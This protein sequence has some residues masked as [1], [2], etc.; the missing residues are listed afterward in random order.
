MSANDLRCGC[1][2]V[3]ASEQPDP[4]GTMMGSGLPVL[5]VDASQCRLEALRAFVQK[6]YDETNCICRMNRLMDI[7]FG[8]RSGIECTKCQAAELLGLSPEKGGEKS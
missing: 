3:L 2:A 7:A 4:D 1:R 6:S 5:A 8:P